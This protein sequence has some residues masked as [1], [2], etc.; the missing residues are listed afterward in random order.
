M[1]ALQLKPLACCPP[2]SSR[3]CVNPPSPERDICAAF[4]LPLEGVPRLRRGEG[5]H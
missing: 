1:L 4:Y 3:S 2:P 5:G